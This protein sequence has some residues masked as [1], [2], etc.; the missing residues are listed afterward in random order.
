M[1]EPSAMQSAL[2]KVK[3]RFLGALPA[4]QAAVRRFLMEFEHS[5]LTEPSL[6]EALRA[7]H[8]IA[9]TAGTLGFKELGEAAL[10]GE[11]EVRELARGSTDHDRLASR[12][13]RVLRLMTE[14]QRQQQ[15]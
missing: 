13:E 7:L 10:D 9:G 8:Q 11:D 3:G 5:Q 1:T 2:A 4:R 6:D 14:A 12:L 15:L